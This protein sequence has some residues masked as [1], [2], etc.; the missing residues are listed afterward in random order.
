VGSGDVYK[1]QITDGSAPVGPA[2]P[3]TCTQ[4][5][6]VSGLVSTLYTTTNP[7]DTGMWGKCL[8]KAA[9]TSVGGT[10]YSGGCY[11]NGGSVMTPPANNHF[12]NMGRNIFRDGGFKDWDLSLFK[13]FRFTERF[14]AQFR[15]EVFNVLNSAIISNPYGAAAGAALG[16]DPSGPSTFGCGCSTPD[17][18]NGNALV[19]S[20][21]ARVIQL[22]LKLSF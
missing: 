18:G 14:G 22:G 5:S 8:A 17:V 10:L 2:N 21:S 4:T 3:V 16:N 19:G 6:G 7:A 11:V 1:R 13:N 9:D 15:F 20:G 12:G